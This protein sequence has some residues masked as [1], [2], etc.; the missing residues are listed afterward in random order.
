MKKRLFT[1]AILTAS[2]LSLNMSCS[3]DF[4]E[5]EFHQEVEQKPL[6]SFNELQSFVR[7]AYVQMRSAKYYGCDFLAYGEIRSDE[8][9]SNKLS[10]YYTTVQDYTMLSTDA[11]AKD[12]WGVIYKM[13]ATTNIAINTD[14]A[15]FQGSETEHNQSYFIQG[16]AH[17]L[18]ALGFFDILRLYGQKYT[19]APDQLGAVLPLQYDPKAKMPRATIAETEAQIEKDFDKAIEIMTKYASVKSITLKGK[20]DLNIEAVKALMSRYYLYKGDYAKVRKLVDEIVAEKTYSIAPQGLLVDTFQYTMNGAA[21]NS[22]FELAV[23]TT[24]SLGT[25]SYRHKL[26]PGGY[27]NLAV[28]ETSY[29]SYAANDVRKALVT[30]NN[31]QYFVTGKYTNNVGAD[32]IKM[33]RYE[34]VIL[35]GVEAELNGGNPAK[36]LEYYKLLLA[37]RL[38]PITNSDGTVNTVEDQL[39][40][41]T[42]VSV[43]DLKK[44]RSK[45]L[46]GEG[47]RQWDLLRWGDTSYANGK[48]KNLLAF[49]IPRIETDLGGSLIKSNP[50]YDN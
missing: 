27:G 36:A 28:K 49:P 47:L 38:K 3:D 41:I 29:T 44:E 16:Q 5:R 33:I 45:E 34:E 11:Y 8:M 32:N 2:V 6:T 37:Q 12:T 43:G 17:A 31:G 48:D 22:I 25:T 10:G 40:L 50:G 7:G 4:V 23:G 18:R 19:N 14:V 35:D 20:T 15:K 24:G 39:K 21:L 30:L 9:S 1:I 26:N 42:S 13:I 46:L